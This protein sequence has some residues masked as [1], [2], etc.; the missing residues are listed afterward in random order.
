MTRYGGI[1]ALS[2]DHETASFDCGSDAQTSWLQQHAL[3]AQ[4]SDSARVYVVCPAGSRRVV[5]FYALSAGAIE[6][7]DAPVRIVKGLGRYPVPAIV[8]TRLGVDLT[9]QGKGLGSGLV[10]DAF[11][12]TA[13]IADRLGVRALLIHAETPDVV[14]FYRRIDPRFEPS[15]TD[16]LHLLLLMKDLRLAIRDAAMKSQTIDG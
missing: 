3:Q 8:L 12:Q 13:S 14:A 1:E 7:E 10:R 9:E 6:R 2:A 4:T 11:L 15:P 5:G 16:P